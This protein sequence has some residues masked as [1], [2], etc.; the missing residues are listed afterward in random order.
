MVVML[1]ALLAVPMSMMALGPASAEAE[2][3]NVVWMNT[4]YKGSD[5]L[6]GAVQAYQAG[7]TATVDVFLQNTAGEALSVTGARVK[8]DWASGEYAASSGG[9]PATL[10]PNETGLATISFAVP[11]VPTASNLVPHSYTVSVDTDREGGY[12]V[13]GPVVGQ[14][15]GVV[16]GSIPRFPLSNSYVDPATVKVYLNGVATTEYTLLQ[17]GDFGFT[18]VL[19]ELTGSPPVG[20]SVTADYVST[21]ILAYGDAHTTVYS[22]GHAPVVPGSEK[23][24]VMNTLSTSHTIDYETGQVR[25]ASPPGLAAH[26][27]VSYRYYQR[28]TRAGNDFAVYSADQAAAMAAREKLVAVG[29]PALNTTGSREL[30][31]KSAM[32]EKLGDQAYA[33]GNL[34]EAR[35]HYDQACRYL[36]DALKGD[37]DPNTL[38]EV[39]STGILLLGIGMVLLAFAAIAHAWR[40]P[41]GRSQ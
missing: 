19:I 39:E 17:I 16:D 29:T 40:R 31:A 20:A 12:V 8:L 38:K 23:I 34:E 11:D 36:D 9:Y 27:D 21:S 25:F 30:A 2:I 28:W 7:S 10:A 18:Q 13:G 26:I 35:G 1:A 3:G 22:L 24:Y 6:L 14:A 33:A 32:E 15:V 41:G 4:A 5:P 37:K